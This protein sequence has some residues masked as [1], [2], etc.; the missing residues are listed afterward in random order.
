MKS[1]NLTISNNS[2]GG[3]TL[4]VDGVIITGCTELEFDHIFP[5]DTIAVTAKFEG[6]QFADHVPDVHKEPCDTIINVDFAAETDGVSFYSNVH[7][8]LVSSMPFPKWMRDYFV[9]FN[10]LSTLTTRDCPVLDLD[11]KQAM[12]ILV[13]E[14]KSVLP[15]WYNRELLIA[16]IEDLEDA[17]DI[18][19]YII[20]N[21]LGV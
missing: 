6:V 10:I 7:Y 21:L 11:M 15:V 5:G 17:G 1:G 18:A 19:D 16:N 12:M 2:L 3:A 13:N 4:S 8:A 9:N 20:Q 14:P